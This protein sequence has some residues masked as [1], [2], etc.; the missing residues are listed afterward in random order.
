MKLI[1]PGVVELA[2]MANEGKFP[3]G[4]YFGATGLASFHDFE[5]Q[6]PADV[7]AMLEKLAAD[8][9]SG[10][11]QTGYGTTPE[12]P[13]T[14]IGTE[15]N[16]IKVFFVPSVEAGVITTGGEVM[17]QA[18][19]QATGLKFK[20]LVPTSYA[21]TIE[22][23]CAS[24]GDSMGF[25]PGLGYVLANARCGVDV[26]FKA[27]RFGNDWYAAQYIVGRDSDIE[28]LADLNG[29]KWAYPDAGSTSGYLYPVYQLNEAGV[30]PS[31]SL[32]AGGHPQA[33]QAVYDGK[34]DFATTFYSPPLKPEGEDA[35]KWGDAP[36][37]PDE[38]IPDCQV[39]DDGTKLMCGEW[40]VLDARA[41]VR[42]QAPDVIEKLRILDLTAQ[43]PNDT[44]SFGPDFPADLRKQIEEALMAFAETEDWDNSIG[45]SDFYGWSSITSATDPEYDPIRNAVEATSFSLEDLPQ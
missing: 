7:K 44:L 42:E 21:A 2:Q 9:K 6:V 10:A 43:I 12:E 26:A 16:P 25:I 24:P 45:S 33:I 30:K 15:A 34:A 17:T 38:L 4:N 27:I 40:R 18:L 22:E 19:E 32:A 20:V 29:K 13:T 14:D 5:D 35:W 8:L 23:M 36:D 41:N 28:T 11:V 39:T 31:E 3:G 37:I 1:T